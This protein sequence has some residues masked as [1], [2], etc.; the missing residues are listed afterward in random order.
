M[1]RRIL[2]VLLGLGTLLGFGAFV[3]RL[4]QGPGPHGWQARRV[5]FERHVAEICSDAA[6]RARAQSPPAPGTALPPAH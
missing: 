5:A 4:R 1:R 3:H 6:L 2:I